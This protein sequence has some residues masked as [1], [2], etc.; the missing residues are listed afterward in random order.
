MMKNL[1]SILAFILVFSFSLHAQTKISGVVKDKE[2][3]ES[4]IGANIRFGSGGTI[5]DIDGNFKFELK[6]FGT[7]YKF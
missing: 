7:I 4:L 1:L 6:I 3:G 2:S 5:T